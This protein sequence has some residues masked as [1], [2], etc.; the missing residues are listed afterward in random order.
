MEAKKEFFSS[1]LRCSLNLSAVLDLQ[2]G[3]F[4]LVQRHNN[5]SFASPSSLHI[6]LAATVAAHP[7]SLNWVV[8]SLITLCSH[9]HHTPQLLRR[10][11]AKS[12][13]E[14]SFAS[15]S[16]LNMEITVSDLGC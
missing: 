7:S 3:R 1:Y 12:P 6:L 11:L 9:L 5:C 10:R 4:T 16:S 8:V 13:N 2:G 14:A 15:P